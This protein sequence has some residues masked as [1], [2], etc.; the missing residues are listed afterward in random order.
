[1]VFSASWHGQIGK[2]GGR[3]APDSR[4]SAIADNPEGDFVVSPRSSE[5]GQAAR[6]DGGGVF[7]WGFI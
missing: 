6:G 4:Y 3:S 5:G 1:M 2:A 7:F